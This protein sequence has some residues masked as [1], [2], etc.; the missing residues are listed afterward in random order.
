LKLQTVEKYIRR[1]V[2]SRETSKIVEN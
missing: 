2:V 1:I